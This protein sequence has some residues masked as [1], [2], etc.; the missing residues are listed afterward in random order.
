MAPTLPATRRI[1]FALVAAAFFF[2]T[3]VVANTDSSVGE[4]FA[5]QIED[6]LQVRTTVLSGWTAS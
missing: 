4:L 5:A 3:L 2:S 6:G 1:G